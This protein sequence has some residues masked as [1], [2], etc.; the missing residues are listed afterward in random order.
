MIPRRA[1]READATRDLY[2]RYARQ[3]YSYCLHQLGNREEAEDA[4]QSTFLNAFRGLQ[5]GIDPEFES[6]W[7]YKIA[8]NVCL[9][10][11]RSSTRRR[12]LETP[13]D[14]DAMQDF[15]P[16][17]QADADELIR[18]PEALDAMPEQQRRALLLREW[19]G[20]S[21]AEIG[22]ELGLSQPAVETLLFRAR[23]SLAAG[24][25]EESPKKAVAKRVRAGSDAG[26]LLALLKS[27]LI[28]GGAKIAAT[29]ATVAATTVIAASPAARHAVEQVVAPAPT[30]HGA[31]PAAVVAQPAAPVA[32]VPVPSAL[33]SAAPAVSS[34]APAPG[35]PLAPVRL[36]TVGAATLAGGHAPPVF[37]DPLV[38][39]TPGPA[40]MPVPEF[41]P[42]P[43]PVPA[44]A[45]APASPPAPAP[46][47][48]PAAPT[49][50][51]TAAAAPS[52]PP[53]TPTV[54]TAT[55]AATPVSTPASTPVSTPAAPPVSA[56]PGQTQ[57]GSGNNGK[58]NGG[59]KDH[60]HATSGSPSTTVNAPAAW[61][62]AAVPAPAA[63]PAPVVE[64]SSVAAPSA[65]PLPA[66][67]VRSGDGH[68]NG[69]DGGHQDSAP[70]A[71]SSSALSAPPPAPAPAPAPA[72]PAP[73]GSSAPSSIP[74]SV[75]FGQP[76]PS[77][78]I[79]PFGPSSHTSAGGD[80]HGDG[81]NGGS[82]DHGGGQGHKR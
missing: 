49:V 28:T 57:K 11:Q 7:L 61:A 32:P 12:R 58:D 60:G 64:A 5:R 39:T 50:A 24:L 27:L 69:K 20:L 78:P 54:A 51:H 22:K 10:R 76:M 75:P 14:L 44:P 37:G 72:P 13:G 25:T 68:G 30:T 23:R 62:P 38:Q 8:Q 31:K 77:A 6:A 47:A 52:E 42:G 29:V 19:Q 15:V 43:A 33:V 70:A 65:P 81:G 18:L 46:A 56:A 80:G 74:S 48:A 3:I 79:L 4:T 71:P 41:V 45:A 63:A 17:H 36:E 16:A 73:A 55:P 67:T 2:E 59:G 82:G 1:A 66:P 53:V 9:T 35:R 26:S 34:F 21:Y 40:A